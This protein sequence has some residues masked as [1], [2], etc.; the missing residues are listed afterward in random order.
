MSRLSRLSWYL[1]LEI[2]WNKMKYKEWWETVFE[3]FTPE[4]H[5]KYQTPNRYMLQHL[6][7]SRSRLPQSSKHD[8]NL[9]WSI[10]PAHMGGMVSWPCPSHVHPMSIQFRSCLFFGFV[11]ISLCP[12]PSSLFIKD[13]ND[14]LTSFACS[15]S[16]LPRSIHKAGTTPKS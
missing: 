9:P 13:T 15:R 4:N 8:A 2:K 3:S 10:A 6:I 14:A 5:S 1:N 16:L 12:L 11:D 7:R